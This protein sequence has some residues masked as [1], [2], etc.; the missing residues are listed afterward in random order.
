MEPVKELNFDQIRKYAMI[1]SYYKYGAVKANYETEKT[2]NC[3]GSIKKRVDKYKQTGNIEFLAD[4]ANFA[5]IEFMY[6]QRNKTYAKNY[7]LDYAKD[8]LP[9][10]SNDNYAKE[11]LRRILYSEYSLLFD[12]LMAADFALN[13]EKYFLIPTHHLDGGIDTVEL[14]LKILDAYDKNGGT[15]K[16]VYVG[17]LARTEF[18]YSQHLTAYYKATDS[19]ESP[20]VDGFGI[21]EIINFQKQL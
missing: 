19:K 15:E 17:N 4:I 14:I 18:F 6:P 5:M 8:K 12:S 9:N 3:I 10:Y 21:N 7:V 2:I 20:G 16:L 11:D 1:V 13:G